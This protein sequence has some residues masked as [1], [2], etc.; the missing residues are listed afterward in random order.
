MPA[1]PEGSSHC[2]AQDARQNLCRTGTRKLGTIDCLQTFAC[3][4]GRAT[5]CQTVEPQLGKGLGPAR[6]KYCD[7][8][9][10]YD[11]NTHS[12]THAHKRTTSSLASHSDLVWHGKR[13][14]DGA[15]WPSHVKEQPQAHLHLHLHGP[16]TAQ[17]QPVPC[18]LPQWT[19]AAA[20]A[21]HVYPCNCY[22]LPESSHQP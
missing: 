2:H 15:Q 4:P 12:R 1:P 21:C 18:S 10:P 20:G 17:A 6:F 19:Q 9:T 7:G 8:C 14:L 3:K 13:L 11:A 22:K 5:G 16:G